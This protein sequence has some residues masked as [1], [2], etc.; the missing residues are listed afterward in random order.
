MMMLDDLTPALLEIRRTRDLPEDV[1]STALAR[2]LARAAGY[3]VEEESDIRIQLDGEHPRLWD[4]VT[5][6]DIALNFGRAEAA[7]A[8]R[9]IMREIERAEQVQLADDFRDAI[10]EIVY[11]TVHSVDNRRTLINLGR[12]M[13]IMPH[14]ERIPGEGFR[15]GGRIKAALVEVG[16]D[17]DALT[18]IVSRRA[19]A[20]VAGLMAE[21]V[22]EITDGLIEVV[23]V[24]RRPG[25][26]AKVAVRAVKGDISPIGPCIGTRGARIRGLRSE[27]RGERIDL[28]S[29]DDPIE[30]QVRRA[31]GPVTVREIIIDE[32]DGTAQSV[33]VIV[34]DEEIEKAVGP[35]GVNAQLAAEI[36]GVPLEIVPLSVRAT[37]GAREMSESGS[38]TRCAALLDTGRRCPNS[39]IPGTGYC[40]LPAHAA[41][42]AAGSAARAEK[43]MAVAVA[44]EDVSPDI[45]DDPASPAGDEE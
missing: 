13:A 40:G 6:E 41:L 9:A 36:T 15:P 16:L 3:P 8:R 11:G 23:Q 24:V 43:D 10:G 17:R 19:P 14:R 21:E 7:S 2:G 4:A 30:E 42:A 5:G 1:V 37:E 28:L 31:L 38:D 44:A 34:P 22:P 39:I 33:R 32:I 12:A 27:L 45:A 26:V 29:A 25:T 18:L 35:H 20:M